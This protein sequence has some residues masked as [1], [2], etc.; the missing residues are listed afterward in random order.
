MDG[1]GPLHRLDIGQVD[2]DRLVV[3]A[4]QHAMQGLVRR[5]I[6]LLMRHEGGHEDEVAG[7]RL[8]DVFEPLAPAHPGAARDDVDHA[9]EH[10]VV[11]HAGLGVGL[12]RHGAGPDLLRTHARVVDRRLAEH[13]GRLGGVRIELAARDHPNPVMLPARFPGRA[14][15]GLPGLGG[16]L[17]MRVVRVVIVHRSGPVPSPAPGGALRGL[18][19]CAAS[20]SPGRRTGPDRPRPRRA[21]RR[22]IRRPTGAPCSA[23][24]CAGAGR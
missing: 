22:G 2:D 6:D 7:A 13:A 23:A 9:L 18:P 8:G 3:R 14:G 17:P 24:G 20:A 12:D 1:L 15:A 10:P 16:S 5:G 21:V 19:A 11:V 4:H